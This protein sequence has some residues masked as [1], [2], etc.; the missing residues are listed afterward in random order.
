MGI[1]AFRSL[2]KKQC[3]EHP[4][5]IRTPG[6]G[7]ASLTWMSYLIVYGRK[8]KK[9]QSAPGPTHPQR[10]RRLIQRDKKEV[11]CIL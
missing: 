5:R 7:R 6:S 8:L 10:N 1:T 4:W 9:H 2:Q 11:I 3:G